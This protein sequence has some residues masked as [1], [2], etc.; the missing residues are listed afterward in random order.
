MTSA[1]QVTDLLCAL[2]DR[3]AARH[4]YSFLAT[5]SAALIKD[6]APYVPRD[7]AL[8]DCARQ[9]SMTRARQRAFNALLN[10]SI[11]GRRP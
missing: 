2:E 3:D 9:A 1:L 5:P 8:Y 7:P 10:A 4:I 6:G 11:H